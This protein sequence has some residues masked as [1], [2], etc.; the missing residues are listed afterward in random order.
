[1]HTRRYS[2]SMWHGI[3]ISNCMLCK[4]WSCVSLCPSNACQNK[5]VLILCLFLKKK[6]K[7]SLELCDNINTV[8]YHND[9]ISASSS[10]S[11]VSPFTN[12]VTACYH[13]SRGPTRYGVTFF[14]PPVDWIFYGASQILPESWETQH[15]TYTMLLKCITLVELLCF[16]F[17]VFFF[18][19]ACVSTSWRNSYIFF[20]HRWTQMYIE[21]NQSVC[22]FT[23][24][25]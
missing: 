5:N 22:V 7:P 18:K 21:F 15:S 12:S 1:M 9:A 17:I 3:G 11:L 19:Q 10:V 14:L 25:I 20:Q 4:N 13:L 8:R 23:S 16:F 2:E 24:A 6:K